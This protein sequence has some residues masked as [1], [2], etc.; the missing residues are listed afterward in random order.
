MLELFTRFGPK[1]RMQGKLG[2]DTYVNTYASPPSP[3]IRPTRPIVFR[4]RCAE[5][6]RV[7]HPTDNAPCQ[8]SSDR[9]AVAVKVDEDVN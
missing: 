6:P 1:G 7:E 3:A 4:T 2:D 5:L 8:T 9:A